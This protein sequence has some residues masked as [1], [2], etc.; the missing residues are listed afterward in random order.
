MNENENKEK[1]KRGAVD[2]FNGI[3]KPNTKMCLK[4]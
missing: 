1:K 4:Y 3:G 2:N